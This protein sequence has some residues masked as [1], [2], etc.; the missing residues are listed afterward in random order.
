MVILAMPVTVCETITFNLSEWTVFESMTFKKWV[1]IM[2]YNV[3]EYVNGWRFNGINDDEK[4]FRIY[5]K[6]FCV[7]HQ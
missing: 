1:N 4:K 3:A 6:P 7:V 5:L 2:S